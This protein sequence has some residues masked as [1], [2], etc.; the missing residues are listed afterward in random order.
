[1]LTNSWQE[2][3]HQILRHLLLNKPSIRVGVVGIGNEL[4]GD[5]GVG[6]FL[7]RRLASLHQE[8]ENLMIL[9]AGPAPENCTSLLRRFAPDLVILIDASEMEQPPGSIKLISW[10]DLLGL[11]ASTH[12]LPLTLFVKYL[13]HELNCEVLLLGIQPIDTTLG[14]DLQPCVRLSA[15]KAALDLARILSDLTSLPATFQ[16]KSSVNSKPLKAIYSELQYEV[17]N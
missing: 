14:E 11:S 7:V 16:E 2:N 13:Q 3:L 1:M 9:D 8:S 6:Q 10:Q 4:R 5:D 15:E 17:K 12:S